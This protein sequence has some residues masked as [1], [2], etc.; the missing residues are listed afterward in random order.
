MAVCVDGT[1]F[2]VDDD[3]QLTFKRDSV[4]IRQMLVYATPGTYTF[5]KPS[6]PGLQKVRVRVVGG[7]GGGAGALASSGESVVRA[8]ASGGAYSESLLD[9]DAL[10]AS[11]TILVGL[12]GAGGVNNDSGNDGGTSAFGG[13]VSAPGGRGSVTT[14]SS[15]TTIG[16]TSGT[17]APGLGTGQIRANGA[18][19]TGAFRFNATSTMTGTGGN[20]GGG[21]GQGG[22][23]R[24][25]ASDGTAGTGYGGG[26]G[27]ATSIG[28]PQTG[29]RGADGVVILELFF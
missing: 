13:Y 24:T 14:M 23:P 8:G 21:L 3:G 26:G 7:G 10:S 16:T 25:F 1:F 11:E 22:P 27:G 17:N 19:G 20:A 5:F 15:G 4:G 29:G 9:A 2:E 6:Y 28:D 18:P 12:G